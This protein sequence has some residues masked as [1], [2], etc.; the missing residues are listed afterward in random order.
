[1]P[2]AAPAPEPDDQSRYI[3]GMSRRQVAAATGLTL[4]TVEAIECK[5]KLELLRT[6]SADPK[7]RHLITRLTTPKPKNNQ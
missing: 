5:F 3:P 4:A 2:V 6:L 1:M 7:T